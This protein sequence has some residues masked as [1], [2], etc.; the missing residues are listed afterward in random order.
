VDPL[1]KITAFN[2]NHEAIPI[3]IY[4]LF[5]TVSIKFLV[6]LLDTLFGMLNLTGKT[7]E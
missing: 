7:I 1:E 2:K 4:S 3:K 6:Y 5:S